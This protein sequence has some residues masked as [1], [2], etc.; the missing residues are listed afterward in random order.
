MKLS[1]YKKITNNDTNT[2]S[3][4]AK[5]INNVGMIALAVTPYIQSNSV[6]MGKSTYKL[7]QMVTLDDFCAKSKQQIEEN[8]EVSIDVP[9]WDDAVSPDGPVFNELHRTAG[10]PIDWNRLVEYI[11]VKN[12]VVDREDVVGDENLIISHLRD[13][14][15]YYFGDSILGG[16]FGCLTY[17]AAQKGTKCLVISELASEILR[18]VRI[19]TG[20][21]EYPEPEVQPEPVAKVSLG[22]GYD[23]EYDFPFESKRAT[24]VEG[25]KKFCS[26]LNESVKNLKLEI[27]DKCLDYCLKKIEADCGS[28]KYD[29]IA[30]VLEEEKTT[31]ANYVKGVAQDYFAT[32]DIAINGKKIDKDHVLKQARKLF[33]EQTTE[34]IIKI[35]SKETI[36]K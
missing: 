26:K 7:R 33:E 35:I 13:L 2:S 20:K 28:I 14:L 1:A 6:D 16:D 21:E 24:N 29:D 31:L 25:Y 19:E 32:K 17:D 15:F 18:K 22:Y 30:K 4:Q 12:L 36:K 8:N 11:K 23:D 10:S 5:P 34:R 27:E 9:F 3:N